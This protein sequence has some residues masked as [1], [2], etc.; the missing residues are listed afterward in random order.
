MKLGVSFFTFP[1]N[2]PVFEALEQCAKAGYEGVELVLS[3]SGDLTPDIPSEKLADIKR[4]VSDL[5]LK[6]ISIGAD[7]VWEHNLASDD[8]HERDLAIDNI[9]R[10]ISFATFF[11]ADLALVVPGWVGTPFTSGQVQYDHAYENS[12][13]SLR[14]LS[15][16]ASSA[17]ITIG[18]ENVWN[19]FLL[20]P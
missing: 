15:P 6:V 14:K 17:K 16:F 20:S 13:E 4:K 3:R 18:I 1:I 19:K 5:G 8:A 11:G 12:Q 2:I 9:K 7:N 10:Q